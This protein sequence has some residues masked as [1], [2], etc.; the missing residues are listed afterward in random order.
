MRSNV[1]AITHHS[2]V[3]GTIFVAI[4]RILQGVAVTLGKRCA[5]L[6]AAMRESRGREAARVLARYRHFYEHSLDEAAGDPRTDR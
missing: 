1:S 5:P 4:P 6:M 3:G 2:A